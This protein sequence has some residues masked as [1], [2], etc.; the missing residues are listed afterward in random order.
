M[1]KKTS[2]FGI[3]IGALFTSKILFVSIMVLISSF[4]LLWYGTDWTLV[5][6]RVLL[7]FIGI[8]L[9]FALQRI[10]SVRNALLNMQEDDRT[11]ANHWAQDFDLIRLTWYLRA[12]YLISAIT[13]IVCVCMVV[14]YDLQELYILGSNLG[15]SGADEATRIRLLDSY[16][17]SSWSFWLGS[18][19]LLIY[20]L[21]ITVEFVATCHI[22]LY[23]KR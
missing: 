7:G 20:F 14:P 4:M 15:Y 6:T 8:G 1:S 17:E 10:P 13:M 23:R 11:I 16:V 12:A 5:L 21:T 22:I 2:S 18:L 9:A 19:S 3:Q